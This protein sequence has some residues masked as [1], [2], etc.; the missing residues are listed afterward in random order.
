MQSFPKKELIRLVR[1]P[2]GN[3]ELDFIGKKSG[4]GAYICKSAACFK[5][6]RKA[7]RFERNLECV[8]P[9]AVY[10]RLEVELSET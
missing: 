6:A 5:K 2:E 10:D 4:R 7:G 1:T 9:D 3:V 8:I